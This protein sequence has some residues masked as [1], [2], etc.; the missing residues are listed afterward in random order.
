[1]PEV[2]NRNSYL[3]VNEE[4]Y[5]EIYILADDSLTVSNK[6]PCIEDVSDSDSDDDKVVKINHVAARRSVPGKMSI[7]YYR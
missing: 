2:V 4:R 1:M 5:N 7:S 6:R 3:L